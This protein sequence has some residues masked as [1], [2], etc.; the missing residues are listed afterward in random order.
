MERERETERKE[1]RGADKQTGRWPT[2]EESRH[3]LYDACNL[4]LYDFVQRPSA[5]I[6]KRGT[7][8][9]TVA[10]TGVRL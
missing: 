10:G 8:V 5:E 2:L 9:E 4:R 3:D 6:I 7:G 1:R